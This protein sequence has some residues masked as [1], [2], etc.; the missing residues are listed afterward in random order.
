MS[1]HLVVCTWLAHAALGGSA[2][3]LAGCLALRA[4]KQPARRL[5]LIELTLLG[6]LVVPWA[7]RLTFLPHWSAGLLGAAPPEPAAEATRLD[8][9]A[10]DEYTADLP[11]PVVAPVAED[12]P[13]ERAVASAPLVSETP[14]R[15]PFKW[16]PLSLLLALAYA[17]AVAVLGA[18]WLIGVMRLRHL[19]RGAKRVPAHVALE[20]WKVAGIRGLRVE[21]LTS[22]RVSLPLTFGVRR[23]VILLP[24]AMCDDPAALRFALAH[25]WS[26]VERRDLLRWH[27]AGLAGLLFFWQPL[28]WWLRRQLR[29]GQDFLAD[30]LAVR[31][32]GEA[33][34]Y[35]AFLVRLAK[36]S[37]GLPAECALAVGGR[38]SNLY[39]RVIMLVNNRE[40]LQRR[41]P[42]PWSL[43]A[44]VLAV[45]LVAAV[46][47]V[48]LDAGDTKSDKEGPKQ[49]IKGSPGEKIGPLNYTGRVTDKDSGKP[50]AGAT[51]TV[52][53]SLYGDPEVKAADWDIEATKHKTDKDGK[54]SFTI[55]AEQA[56]MRY[57][58][59]ELDAE[60][61]G[62]APQRGFG[63]AL[64][65]ILKNEKLGG[66][67]FFEDVT[68]RAGQDV[69]GTVETPDGKPA[70]GVKVLAYSVTNKR[71]DNFEYGSFND[72][73]TDAKGKF[74]LTVVTP[75]D[76][77]FWVLPKNYAPSAHGVKDNKRGDVGKIGLEKGLVFRGK[78]LDA[79]GK[80]MSGVYVTMDRQDRDEA[81]ARLAVAD[82]VGRCAVSNDK[83]EFEMMPL[84]PGT[85]RLHVTDYNGE[86][87]RDERRFDRRRPPAVFLP[88]T[89]KLTAGDKP[90]PWEL[91]AVPHV[92]VEAQYFD[93][94]GKKRRG[95]EPFLF[96]QID[97]QSWF[98]DAKADADG[99]VTVLAPH[100]LENARLQMMTNEHGSLRWRK[101]KDE[102]LSRGR[103]I[104]LGTLDHDVKGIEIV[105]YDAP[106]V[107]VKVTAK[108]GGKPKGATVTALYRDEKGPKEGRFVMKGNRESD[109]HFEEQED[110][111]FRSEQLLP[112]EEVAVTAHAEG[113]Q[114]ATV[115]VN[116]AEGKTKDVE[117]VLTKK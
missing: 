39:R 38:R 94:K 58:Y 98:M 6:C 57:L 95:H 28:F 7:A 104:N 64:S 109:V 35:A 111:R 97:G 23:P 62:Y 3:L 115:T 14:S 10:D 114:D 117:I 76:C 105:R 85:F 1:W 47:A 101:S 24:E 112:D 81:L 75:G 43:A 8:T 84:P 27:L 72:T 46:S 83:G 110:G 113:Y 78:V 15:A 11:A 74:S 66:R 42:A 33:E 45:A 60:A 106:I 80:P 59:I 116:I 5:R 108:D 16:P 103:E 93:S 88:Q 20:F 19:L 53:R 29:L 18:R 36:R 65:M 69:T 4:C 17:A 67:P 61:P 48:R 100:G 44:A 37:V 79:Q 89:V 55:P 92:V 51:V 86:P 13:A 50:I 49:A 26:H 22:D 52:H 70:A 9:T 107:L 25:E 71:G 102:P 2:V 56:S 40:P 31:Q 96:G 77:V 82:S 91:R 63:Y 87:S 90:D 30:G 41:C 68:L 99:K 73:K 12:A 34:D 21:L 32:A 54:Y